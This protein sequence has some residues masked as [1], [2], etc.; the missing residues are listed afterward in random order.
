MLTLVHEEEKGDTACG[1]VLVCD[2][3]PFNIVA[4]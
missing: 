1:K 4:I 2:D 3:C